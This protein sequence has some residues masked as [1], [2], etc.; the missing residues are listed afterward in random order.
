LIFGGLQGTG[1]HGTARWRGLRRHGIYRVAGRRFKAMIVRARA[2]GMEL[3]GQ[4]EV[5]AA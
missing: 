5:V 1:R 4:V 3:D 2:A